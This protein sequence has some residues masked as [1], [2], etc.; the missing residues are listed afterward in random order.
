[1]TLETTN[2]ARRWVCAQVRQARRDTENLKP[3]LAIYAALANKVNRGGG[4]VFY[5]RDARVVVRAKGLGLDLG[6]LTDRLYFE[7]S[8]GGG[9]FYTPYQQKIHLSLAISPDDGTYKALVKSVVK[10]SKGKI[11]HELVHH[12]DYQRMKGGWDEAEKSYVGLFQDKAKYFNHPIEM[13]AYFQQGSAPVMEEYKELLAGL[14]PD[15]P[16]DTDHQ[17][18]VWNLGDMAV[19]PFNGFFKDWKRHLL[20][21][22]WPSLTKANQRRMQKRVYDLYDHV[23]VGAQRRL[24]ELRRQ[25]DPAALAF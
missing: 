23:V 3:A 4:M 14:R 1:M 11:I 17:L 22:F 24:K 19:T 15:K 13:N 25:K 6:P 5:P 20:P 10:R 8:S 16:E 7:F 18:A 21:D 12:I 9:I 2:L